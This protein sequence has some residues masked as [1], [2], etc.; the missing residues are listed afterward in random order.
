MVEVKQKYNSRIIDH[1]KQ[2]Q[3]KKFPDIQPEKP[4]NKHDQ[5]DREYP[6]SERLGVI[7]NYR[8]PESGYRHLEKSQ[9]WI[10]KPFIKS[11]SD[12]HIYRD[13]ADKNS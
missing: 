11:G 7:Q 13:I 8:S 9:A 10:F 2:R 12:Y 1:S 3:K 5:I 4:E 6:A